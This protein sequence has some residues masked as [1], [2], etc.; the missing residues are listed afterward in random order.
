MSFSRDDWPIAAAMLQFPASRPDG[1]TTFDAHPDVWLEAFDEIRDA[2]FDRV[3][4]NDRWLRIGDLAPAR[5]DALVDSGRQAGLAL[6]SVCVVR[7]SVIDPDEGAANL[8]YTHRTLEAAARIGA[9][10]VSIGFHRPLTEE[11]SARLWFWTAQGP[12]DAPD[13]P[14]NWRLAVDR[15]T[16]L[17]RHAAD[18]GLQLTLEMYEDSYLGTGAQAVRFVTEVGLDNVGLNPDVGNLVRLHRPID[19]WRETL[20]VTLPHANYWHVKNYARDENPAA[21]LYTAMP[22]SLELGVIDY[23]QAV[24]EALSAGFRGMFVCEHYGGDGLSVAASNRDYLRR[25]LPSQSR[26]RAEEAVAS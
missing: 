9:E 5:L 26:R 1:T 12:V 19:D 14:D 10:I 18:L 22:T 6:S 4:I 17:G 8:E 21:D 11:Q 23:R 3:E 20:R 2:G 7:S 16:E 25:V 15:V 24:K 13:D